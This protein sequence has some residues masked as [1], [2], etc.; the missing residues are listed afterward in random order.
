MQLSS[1]RTLVSTLDKQLKVA[2]AREKKLK[3]EAKHAYTQGWD[4]SW[5]VGKKAAHADSEGEEDERWETNSG[6]SADAAYVAELDPCY[7]D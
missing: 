3:I 4:D 2:Q 6:C 1:L 5:L 7:R